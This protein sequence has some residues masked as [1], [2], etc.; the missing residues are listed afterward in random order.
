[1]SKAVYRGDLKNLA[2]RTIESIQLLGVYDDELVITLDSDEYLVFVPKD[3][4]EI[5][6]IAR[7]DDGINSWYRR[8][9]GWIS[10]DEYDREEADRLAANK[11]ECRERELAQLAR[12]KRIYER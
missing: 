10:K 4:D 6:G 1:M 3:S 7:D 8:E 5:T 12:L 11:A 2:G 9:L